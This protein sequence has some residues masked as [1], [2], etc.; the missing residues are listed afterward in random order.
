MYLSNYS[1]LL[2]LGHH[3]QVYI[4]C[5]KPK[6]YLLL[7]CLCFFGCGVW[8]LGF[9]FQSWYHCSVQ[10]LGLSTCVQLKIKKCSICFQADSSF[11]FCCY[12]GH[13]CNEEQLWAN[14]SVVI[15]FVLAIYSYST[16]TCNLWHHEKNPLHFLHL[17]PKPIN[18]SG[19][20]C[21]RQ[22]VHVHVLLFEA[23]SFLLQVPSWEIF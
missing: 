23:A 7:F 21:L 19:D 14:G 3:Q 15:L 9:F 5:C 1:L 8:G 10:H 6:L 16:G 13:Y 17:L 12:L 22:D 4:Q 20:F 11:I 2:I 18:Y